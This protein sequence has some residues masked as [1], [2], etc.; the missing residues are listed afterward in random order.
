MDLDSFSANFIKYLY[1]VHCALVSLG[2]QKIVTFAGWGP[3][4]YG[5]GP[6][7]VCPFKKVETNH[8]LSSAAAGQIC[9]WITLFALDD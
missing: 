7:A 6:H 5:L 1:F 9:V 8:L 4:N 2:S 3:G